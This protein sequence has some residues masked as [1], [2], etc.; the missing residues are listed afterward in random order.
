MNRIIF[1]S[2]FLF[3]V[4]NAALSQQINFYYDKSFSF[5]F[6]RTVPVGFEIITI[7]HDT[8]KTKGFLNGNLSWKKLDINVSG[9]KLK[10]G[11]LTINSYEEFKDKYE[12]SF[13][14][15]YKKIN[16]T[17]IINYPLGFSGIE[18]ADYRPEKGKDA[19]NRLS[20]FLLPIIFKSWCLDGKD[21]RDGGQGNNGPFL[22]A[23]I[24]LKEINA[25]K[26]L[27]A[28]IHNQEK[29]KVNTYF[30][31]A[32]NGVLRILADG[33]DG[34]SGG[35]GGPGE[36]CDDG[37]GG[38]GGKGGNGGDGGN[39]GVVEIKINEKTRP[40]LKNIIISNKGGKGGEFGRGGFDGNE[41]W[42]P[43]FGQDNGRNGEKGFDGVD[44]PPVTILEK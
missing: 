19:R 33:S 5:N 41:F 23:D 11:Y 43:N 16:S 8:L 10:D 15:E 26:I 42:G 28:K 34:G 2:G 36:E 30:V 17:E 29:N 6:N 27:I 1:F 25:Q 40:Y 37:V 12:L 44:G 24:D 18:I 13:E 39:G 35:K 32:E 20:R 14:V 31:N 9:G 21:G 22:H 38:A 7:D 4:F 3:L